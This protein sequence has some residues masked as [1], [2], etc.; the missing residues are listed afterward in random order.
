MK[1]VIIVPTYNERE[2][3]APLIE[4]LQH[5]FEKLTH[6][7]HVLVVDDNSPD[8]TA[9]FV[10]ELQA[11]HSNLHLLMGEKKGLGVAYIRHR[12][13]LRARREH[14]KRM[15]TIP[16]SEFAIRKHRRTLSG[17]NIFGA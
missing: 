11:G 6:D 2:N 15:G 7:M 16:S 12:Q 13:P 4:A 8:R 1:T 10:R 9:D 17:R 14:S 5:Q 3:I